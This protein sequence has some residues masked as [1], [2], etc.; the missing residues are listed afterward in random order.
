MKVSLKAKLTALISLLVL[1]VVLATSTLYLSNLVQQ[2]LV[3]IGSR[4]DYVANETYSQARDVLAQSHMPAGSDPSQYPQ[5]RA[6]V[7]TTLGQDPGLNSLLQ[8]ALSYSPTVYYIAITD[9][10]GQVLVHNDPDEIG[11]PFAPAPPFSQLTRASLLHQLRVIYGPTARV[12]EIVLPLEMGGQP[13]WVRV[14]VSTLFVRDE[15]EAVL[16]LGLVGAAVEVV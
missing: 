8:S 9:S 6:F 13:M 7:Q 10:Q 16:V 14:G 4:G 11:H 1:L 3:A 5:L 12:Y 15:T 2:A